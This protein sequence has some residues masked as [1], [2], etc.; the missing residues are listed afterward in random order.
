MG[1]QTIRD[2]VKKTYKEVGIE[3]P[4][5]ADTQGKYCFENAML[6]NKEDL[7]PGDLIFYSYE[8]NGCFRNISHV[9]IYVGDGMMV[10]ATNP[11][12]GVIASS[13]S[14]WINSSGTS[15]LSIRRIQ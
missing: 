10:H 4:T 9:A 2:L 11:S 15:I 8:E 3:L 13:V 5:V 6:V 14:H 7:K 1:V 12:T